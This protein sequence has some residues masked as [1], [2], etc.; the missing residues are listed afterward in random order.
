MPEM[1]NVL[2][3]DAIN[4]RSGGGV[5]H[6]VNLLEYADPSRFGFE[7]VHIWANK[8]L[9]SRLKHQTYFQLVSFR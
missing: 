9:A 8:N 7:C 1:N 6:I 3:I 2:S 4:V 5:A